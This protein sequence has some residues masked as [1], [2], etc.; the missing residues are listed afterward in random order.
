MKVSTGNNLKSRAVDALVGRHQSM[1]APEA[2][3]LLTGKQGL[4]L[5]TEILWPRARLLR[6]AWHNRPE[7]QAQVQSCL[8]AVMAC[9]GWQGVDDTGQD[10]DGVPEQCAPDEAESS[11]KRHNV[12]AVL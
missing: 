7:W 11:R 4:D 10:G 9:L 6:R 12:T 8:E 2:V 5:D 1:R 3:R